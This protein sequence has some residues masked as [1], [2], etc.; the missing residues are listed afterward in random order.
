M[1]KDVN[2]MTKEEMADLIG[3][4]E[5]SLKQI[6]RVS[7]M[8]QAGKSWPTYDGQELDR[9][10]YV[11]AS[12]ATS[13]ARRLAFNKKAGK[14]TV[15]IEDYWESMT[16]DEFNFQLLNMPNNDKRG[17]FE[18][19]NTMED[20]A[21]Q[22]LRAM[23]SPNEVFKCLGDEQLSFYTNKKKVSGTPDGIW[24]NLETMKYRVLEF[25]STQNPITQPKEGHVAQ[26]NVNA[27]LIKDLATVGLL[28][29]PLGLPIK[30][31]ELE[32][33]NILYI[34]TDNWL[35]MNEFRLPFD[36]NVSYEQA[37]AKARKIWK[38]E[39][40]KIVLRDPAEVE[41]EG[42][43]TWNGCMFC[44][45]KS[46]CYAIEQAANDKAT[47]SKL[48]NL[49]AA[50]EGRAPRKLPAMPSFKADA[51]KDKIAALLLEYDMARAQESEGKKHKEDVAK[52]VKAWIATQTG[53][54]AEFADD[55]VVFSA[56]LTESKRS[57]GIDKEALEVFLKMHDLELDDYEK[58]DTTVET[59][60]VTV[61]RVAQDV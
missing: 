7:V 52:A 41:P 8:T 53:R 30:D 12:E 4:G 15:A 14:A 18:R 24:L 19:G 16:D 50:E 42:L 2:D 17:I 9:N 43:K 61:K 48:A 59:L 60:N 37:A 35:D 33:V 32:G 23:W 36:G 28:D 45:N 25:K 6:I 47:A 38:K 40:G 44:E 13:C 1:A 39:G 20:W 5:F 29:D 11:T 49:I 21:V 51:P 3:D 54:A 26:V 10:E 58:P 34:H 57:G 56:K 46:A 27:G 22:H 31:M 55:G